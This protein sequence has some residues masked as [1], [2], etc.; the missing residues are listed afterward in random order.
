MLLGEAGYSSFQDPGKF[1]FPVQWSQIWQPPL[2][3]GFLLP[4]PARYEAA[5]VFCSQVQ[6]VVKLSMASHT[7]AHTCTHA[8]LHYTDTLDQR[9]N[10]GTTTT[11]RALINMNN[12]NNLIL[13]MRLPANEAQSLLADL[14]HTNTPVD[15]SSSWL[16]PMV[17][18]VGGCQTSGSTCWLNWLDNSQNNEIL[19]WDFSRNHCENK[20]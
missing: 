12:A 13:L 20:P 9:T 3:K 18:P 4:Q 10:M 16:R 1:S 2:P 8:Y 7:H 5:V 15:L 14:S 19:R 6:P 17:L 11:H